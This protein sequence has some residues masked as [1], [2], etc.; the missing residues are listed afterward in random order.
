MLYDLRNGPCAEELINDILPTKRGH[1]GCTRYG[2]R[3]F[4]G[5][6]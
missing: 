4:I 2:N 5:A 6:E 1:R 3:G